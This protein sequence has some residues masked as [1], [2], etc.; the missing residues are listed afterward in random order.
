MSYTFSNRGTFSNAILNVIVEM[1]DP[2][3]EFFQPGGYYHMRS[4]LPENVLQEHPS[5][6]LTLSEYNDLTLGTNSNLRR[7]SMTFLSANKKDNLSNNLGVEI[8][9]S[10]N[11]TKNLYCF[12]LDT[13]SSS[14]LIIEQQATVGY[15]VY[16]DDTMLYVSSHMLHGYTNNINIDLPPS[17]GIDSL[18]L[19]SDE[20]KI[21]LNHLVVD[22]NGVL[23][24]VGQI[25]TDGFV[26]MRRDITYKYLGIPFVIKSSTTLG[27]DSMQYIATTF[28]NDFDLIS[29]RFIGRY[30]YIIDAGHDAIWQFSSVAKNNNNE[31]VM[32][33]RL[34]S[35]A[36]I[37]T[38]GNDVINIPNILLPRVI[39]VIPMAF[40]AVNTIGSTDYINFMPSFL[41]IGTK[42][43][44]ENL[45]VNGTGSV[46][47]VFKVYNSASTQPFKLTFESN[48]AVLYDKLSIST[49]NVTANSD[50][51][52]QGNITYSGMFAQSDCRVKHKIRNV[53]PSDD[54]TKLLTLDVKEYSFINDPQQYMHKGVLAHEIQHIYPEAVTQKMT[55]FYLKDP[56][57]A[58][59]TGSIIKLKYHGYENLMSKVQNGIGVLLIK[60]NCALYKCKVLQYTYDNEALFHV[61]IID[62]TLTESTVDIIGVEDTFAS[63]NYQYLFMSAINAIKSLYE[64]IRML[65]NK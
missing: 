43:V 41:G 1:T 2:G 16:N 12:L 11:G 15:A 31:I 46:R 49:S 65:K 48:I 33:L 36:L 58:S 30:I 63:V 27:T 53:N 7:Y 32:T 44:T 22:N 64:D 25:L 39:F 9:N 13:L 23:I 4:S 24:D 54:L 10:L 57:N 62:K 60:S 6:I 45:T 50:M 29:K 42:M 51:H 28:Y 21:V 34:N 40:I 52:V 19:D 3:V 55:T 26:V 17:Q 8:S 61:F 18:T 47:D 5:N 56:I 38:Y 37:D 14:N 20:A 35:S 59:C